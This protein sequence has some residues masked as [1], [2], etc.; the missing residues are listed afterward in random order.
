MKK[1]LF[2]LLA[3]FLVLAACGN[4]ND[5]K[6]S[7][8]QENSKLSDEKQEEMY[9]KETKKLGD[10]LADD[11]SEVEEEAKST[12]SNSSSDISKDDVKEA[13]KD[14][15]DFEDNTKHLDKANKEVGNHALKTAKAM[16]AYAERNVELEEFKK[17]N[18]E[19]ENSYDLAMIDA[20]FSLFAT[21]E[22]IQMDYEDLDVE[23]KKEYLGT[24]GNEGV[25]DLLAITA[26]TDIM[27]LGEGMGALI[28][29]Y[30]ENLNSK[31]NKELSN[32]NYRTK[33]FKSMITEE[34][35]ISKKEYNSMVKDFNDLSPEF[36]HYDEVNKM[37]STTEYNYFM[38]LR[39]GVVG[40]ETDSE[41]EEHKLD[42]DSSKVDDV[43]IEDNSSDRE[44]TVT[45]DNV[46]DYVEEYEGE[47]L[48]TENY[49]Y[50]EPEKTEDDEWGF[51]YTDKDGDL[52]GSYIVDEDGNVTKYDENGEDY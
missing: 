26:D 24:K 5:S 30:D 21:Y 33:V 46:I 12:D 43:E 1:V 40:A 48:D 31:Q 9:K 6:S 52:A 23:Y 50:K 47:S 15:K 28:I 51:S 42:D 7:G 37:V 22:T 41:V 3:S 13:K 16:I 19:L 18:P 29:K 49:T 45:R 36:L 32:T 4:N 17:D 2:L 25:T 34:P 39:N 27:E 10:L 11:S 35:D 8:K 38:D 20:T 14:I 44:E